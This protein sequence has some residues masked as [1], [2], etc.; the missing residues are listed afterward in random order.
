MPIQTGRKN[1]KPKKST[2]ELIKELRNEIAE[3]N[4]VIESLQEQVELVQSAVDEIIFG[5]A[6]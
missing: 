2:D 6:F 4:E 5:G 3:K 1:E